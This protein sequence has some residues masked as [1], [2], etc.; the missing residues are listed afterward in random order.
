[1]Y[2]PAY[3]YGPPPSNNSS[4][5]NHP[6]QPQQQ[7]HGQQQPQQ[8][9]YYPQAY[10]AAPQQPSYDMSGAAAMGGSAESMAMT[11][12]QDSGMAHLPGGGMFALIPCYRA[13]RCS[14]IYML[15]YPL[16]ALS[17]W[18]AL[19]KSLHSGNLVLSMRLRRSASFPMSPSAKA[20]PPTYN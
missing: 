16:P 14:A 17:P 11:P 13:V 10:G 7:Q 12:Q 4:P 9:M 2:G 1:M 18:N 3:G 8:M 15:L 6:H 19:H 5:F 20:F